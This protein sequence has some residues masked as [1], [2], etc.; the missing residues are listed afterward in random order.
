MLWMVIAEKRGHPS[1]YRAMPLRGLW[2]ASEIIAWTC[3]EYPRH[4]VYFELV[5]WPD[6]S[7]DTLAAARRFCRVNPTLPG[8][9]KLRQAVSDFD[10]G[11]GIP[12]SD[13]MIPLQSHPNPKRF[14]EIPELNLTN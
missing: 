10:E 5:H 7:I 1:S 14:P 11:R 9:D 4:V 13:D 2:E 12:L 6:E 3:R 8:I